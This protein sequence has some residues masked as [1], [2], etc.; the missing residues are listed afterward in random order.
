MRNARH[1]AATLV[2]GLLAGVGLA[3]AADAHAAGTILHE[4]AA[5][6]L[7]EEFMPTLL[8]LADAA[9]REPLTWAIPAAVALPWLLRRQRASRPPR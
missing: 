2:T 8:A 5:E 4:M 9:L 7:V 1:P 6:F 3:G